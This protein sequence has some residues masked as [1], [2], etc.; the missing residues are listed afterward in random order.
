MPKIYIA[1]DHAGYALKE[2]LV[3][4]IGTLGYEVEDVGAYSLDANDDYPDLI[5]PCA[6][7]VAEDAG[8]IGVIL[9]ASGQGEAMVANR[10]PGIRAAVFYG[11][12][13]SEQQDAAGHVL[14]LVASAR[15]HNDANMLSLGARFITEEEAKEAVKTFLSTPFSHEERH[16]RRIAKF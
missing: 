12:P 8:S 9:G 16:V 1:T 10:V 3:P 14:D 2:V 7:K 6:K 5:M 11:A 13:A 4:Y 15:A